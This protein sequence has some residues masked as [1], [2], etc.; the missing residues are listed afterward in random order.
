[1]PHQPFCIFTPASFSR[2]RA[3]LPLMMVKT[4]AQHFSPL[5]PFPSFA[6]RSA[7]VRMTDLAVRLHRV[8]TFVFSSSKKKEEENLSEQQEECSFKVC[9]P[10][11][12]FIVNETGSSVEEPIKKWQAR[13]CQCCA[14]YVKWVSLLS[15][16]SVGSKL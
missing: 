3:F 5:L 15:N 2:K 14:V 16:C 11:S 12:P 10:Y 13:A 6:D 4:L 7:A 1:M 9:P 8:H